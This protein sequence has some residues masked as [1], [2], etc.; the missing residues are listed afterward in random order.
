[1]AADLLTSLDAGSI[2]LRIAADI[3]ADVTPEQRETIAGWVREVAT[4]GEVLFVLR[5]DNSDFKSVVMD[6]MES[7]HVTEDVLRSLANRNRWQRLAER[8]LL[9]VDFPESYG[10]FADALVL[11]S[12]IKQGN[13]SRC[14]RWSSD[15]ALLIRA[16]CEVSKTSASRLARAVERH[17]E[18]DGRTTGRY[19]GALVFAASGVAALPTT[20][21]QEIE[22][23]LGAVE[24]IARYNEN[25]RTRG[26]EVEVDEAL[27]RITAHPSMKADALARFALEEDASTAALRALAARKDVRGRA[28]VTGKLEKTDDASVLAH[29]A[30]DASGE[31]FRALWLRVAE[32]ETELALD[33]LEGR[34][35]VAGVIRTDDLEP[36]LT[37]SDRGVRLRALTFLE[38]VGAGARTPRPRDDAKPRAPAR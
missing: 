18:P 25:P 28:E 16:G 31:R 34:R 10:R 33:L 19:R 13:S 26:Q 5:S 11:D 7:R 21:A 29:L 37:S 22:A 20:N 17:A 36:F 38:H 9:P 15:M 12:W 4:P 35:E 32:K 30:R 6:A 2:V 23:M 3:H 14:Q 27:E 24:T 1:M 8:R